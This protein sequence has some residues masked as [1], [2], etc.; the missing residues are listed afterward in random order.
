MTIVINSSPSLKIEA[1]QLLTE[2]IE[3]HIVH[4]NVSE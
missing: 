1:I 2:I 3:N 4:D